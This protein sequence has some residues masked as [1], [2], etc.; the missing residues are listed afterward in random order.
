MRRLALI[1]LATLVAAC[2]GATS[3]AT[4]SPTPATTPTADVVD[5]IPPIKG[6]GVITFGTAY[7]P[8]TLLIA[9][10]L[11]RFKRTVK[12]IAWSAQFVESAGATSVELVLASVSKT[13]AETIIDRVDVPVSSPEFDLLANKG[14]LA[15]VVGNK[16][17]TYVLRYVR[18]GTVLAEGTFTL[19]K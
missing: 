6:L 7:D 10:P 4:A 17:G 11:T 19:V 13:G 18:E 3:M 1:A 15:G 5:T 8:D 12:A 16:A 2:G 14:D 9:K